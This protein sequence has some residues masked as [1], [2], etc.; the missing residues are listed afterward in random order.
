MDKALTA[1]KDRYEPHSKY[2][3]I[4]VSPPFNAALHSVNIKQTENSPHTKSSDYKL[5]PSSLTSLPP[6]AEPQP[7]KLTD[8]SAISRNQLRQRRHEEEE[9]GKQFLFE[10]WTSPSVVAVNLSRN[11]RQ[12]SRPRTFWGDL[13]SGQRAPTGKRTSRCPPRWEENCLR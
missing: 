9:A 10:V 8:H 13:H 1:S 12:N 2:R 7:Q 5:T 11:W 3:T 4:D 6:L